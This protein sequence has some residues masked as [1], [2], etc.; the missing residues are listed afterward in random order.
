MRKIYYNRKSIR[1]KNY[2]Y[3]QN[4]MYFITICT[5]NREPILSKINKI[6]DVGAGLVPAHDGKMI[7]EIELTH[8]GKMIEQEIKNIEN[9]FPIK[10]EQ[11]VIMPNHIHLIINFCILKWNGNEINDI[12]RAGTRP[13]PTIQNIVRDF[14]YITSVEYINYNKQIGKFK[15]LWQRGYYEHIICN[16]NEYYRICK[17]IKNN[18]KKY[19]EEL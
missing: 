12:Q 10:I 3:S 4:G 11:Y 5:K 6:G 17:Y 16:E 13:A 7:Y 15:K 9:N 8:I 19:L 14:K 18:P 1:L 2:D